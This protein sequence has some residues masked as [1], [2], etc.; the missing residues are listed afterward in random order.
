MKPEIPKSK[1]FCLEVM[2]SRL[3]GS[4][5]SII[6]VPKLPLADILQKVLLKISQYS[7]E[8]TCVGVSF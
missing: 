1:N 4:V 3:A 7:W 6:K 8:D 2:D 5:I